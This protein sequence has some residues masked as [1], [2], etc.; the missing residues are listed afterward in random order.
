M[1]K[2]NTSSEEVYNDK[3]GRF[4]GEASNSLSEIYTKLETINDR[5]EGIEEKLEKL[6]KLEK[7]RENTEYTVE[8]FKTK[9]YLCDPDI[10]EEDLVCV[11]FNTDTNASGLHRSIKKV[12]N[13]S[14]VVIHEGK[15]VLIE[16]S[17]VEKVGHSPAIKYL[18]I[19]ELVEQDLICQK[20]NKNTTTL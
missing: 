9:P 20:Y 5:I 3:I 6:E 13:D 18:I 15:E 17:K 7:I 1:S 16:K 14:I 19:Q 11:H 10:K 8:R 4:F 12:F 2:R